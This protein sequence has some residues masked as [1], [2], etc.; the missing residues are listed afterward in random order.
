MAHL[1]QYRTL[2]LLSLGG[3]GLLDIIDILGHSLI[4]AFRVLPL[5]ALALAL[6]LT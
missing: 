3:I 1:G 6:A 4:V 5:V 2:L